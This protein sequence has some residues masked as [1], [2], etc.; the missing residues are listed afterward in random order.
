MELK[1][2]MEETQIDTI[3]SRGP[4]NGITDAD[5]RIISNGNPE[6]QDMRS[7]GDNDDT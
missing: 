1:T 5:M 3:I 2:L 4:S 6:T 7:D